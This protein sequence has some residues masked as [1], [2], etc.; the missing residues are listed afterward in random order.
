VMVVFALLL[1]LILLSL[2]LLD[3]AWK[4]CRLTGWQIF[5]TFQPSSSNPKGCSSAAA[6]ENRCHDN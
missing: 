3:V 5:S 4:G 1:Y 2:F 6:K